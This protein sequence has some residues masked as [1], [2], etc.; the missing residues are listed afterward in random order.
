[1]GDLLIVPNLHNR[2]QGDYVNSPLVQKGL[3]VL[4]VAHHGVVDTWRERERQMRSR[5]V[6]LTLVSAIVWN[7]GGA[8]VSLNSA[9]D[10]FVIGVK[11]FGV[12]PNLFAYDPRPLWRL[13]GERWDLIDLHEE[14][15][16]LATY[17][18]LLL[19]TLRRQRAPFVLYSAQNIEKRYPVPFRWMERHAL[20]HASGAYVCNQEAGQILHRKGLRGP[21]SVL[22][23]GVDLSVF[24]PDRRD[25]PS[26]P[27]RVGYSGRLESYKGVDVLLRAVAQMPES[28][29]ELAGDGPSRATLER[30]GAELGL[31]DRVRF[32]GH[33][34]AGLPDF[35][36]ELD[37][38]VVPSVP[39]PGWLEQFGRVVVE[40]MASG[41]PVIASRS[42]ALP[43]VVG[44]AG[45]LV[46][47]GDPAA[48]A[49]ALVELADVERWRAVREAGLARSQDY[50]WSA[51]ALGQLECYAASLAPLVSDVDRLPE[52]VVVAY[53][54][55]APLADALAPLAGY[56]ITVVDNSS[57]SATR[58]VVERCHAHYVDPRRNIGFAAGVNQ[59][60]ASLEARG[61]GDAD[62][63]LLNPDAVVAARS[64]QRLQE[65]LHASP[66]HACVAPAQ[67]RPDSTEQERVR[68]PFPSPASAWR[69]AIGLGRLDRRSG[70]VIGSVL[71][72]RAS[73]LAE[74][75]RF[76]ERFFLYAE[77][78]DWQYRAAQ[79]GWTTAVVPDATA[80]HVGAGTGGSKSRRSELFHTSLL[81]YMS[82]HYGR[83]GELSFR[84]AMLAGAALR[85][86]LAQGEARTAARWRMRFYW[87]APQSERRSEHA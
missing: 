65:V 24:H 72:L 74:V 8:P 2:Q 45:L 49:S 26:R 21:A 53:G 42:G 81:A 30:L 85:S 29:L 19:R 50:S 68:W 54:P 15:C 69:E 5:G 46:P 18:I 6:D 86:V 83:W 75:G 39:T 28:T 70:F 9:G 78:T 64:V 16:S 51:I 34:G 48:I 56:S 14:P 31:G 4:R 43:E 61:L 38:L 22:G 44:K 58:E 80:T 67:T 41:V 36:K 55:A 7:E 82:K 35:Y 79:A 33:L 84:M 37:V 62:V 66:T 32:R 71:L 63:L 20:M 12:H 25:R 87:T 17:E 76:D 47:P 27:L 73:A 60:L 3:R 59:A 23:L 40:A 52:I 11:T 57:S 1:M 77:E 10:S 13:L